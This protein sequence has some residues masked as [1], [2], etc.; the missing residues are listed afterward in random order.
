MEV[1]KGY[2]I[3]DSVAGQENK[4]LSTRTAPV[5]PVFKARVVGSTRR[6]TRPCP[7]FIEEETTLLFPSPPLLKTSS[8]Y[9]TVQLRFLNLNLSL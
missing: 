8:A 9:F 1:R 7:R 6:K 4:E 2:L 5:D 3:L